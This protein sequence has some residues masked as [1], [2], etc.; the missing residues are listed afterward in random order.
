MMWS[1]GPDARRIHSVGKAISTLCASSSAT[2]RLAVLRLSRKRS[3][4]MLKSAHAELSST[5]GQ[6]R[7]T[8]VSVPGLKSQTASADCFLL[9]LSLAFWTNH[10]VLACL[11][12]SVSG[13]VGACCPSSV[14]EG[15]SMK[16]SSSSRRSF[17]GAICWPVNASASTFFRKAS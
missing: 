11:P 14:L 17:S 13:K 2:M 10:L 8:M 5:K 4:Q 15:R 3:R 16:L 1:V 9:D 12:A 7:S 6:L